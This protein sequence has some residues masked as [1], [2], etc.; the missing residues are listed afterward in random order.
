MPDILVLWSRVSIIKYISSSKMPSMMRNRQEGINELTFVS[1]QASCITA[2]RTTH[3]QLSIFMR[4]GVER[5]CQYPTLFENA[6][7]GEQKRLQ[8]F[9][10][11]AASPQ[12]CDLQ[13]FSKERTASSSGSQCST[14]PFRTQRGNVCVFCT[15]SR[16]TRTRSVSSFS[17]LL[18]N[19]RT[20]LTIFA[21][22]F[23]VFLQPLDVLP[24]GLQISLG[25]ARPIWSQRKGENEEKGRRRT[26]SLRY[27]KMQKI[28]AQVSFVFTKES[29]CAVFGMSI[30]YSSK[31]FKSKKRTL[32]I[33]TFFFQ[34]PWKHRF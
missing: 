1:E 14:K 33:F 11:F 18:S 27:Y 26:G 4:S 34:K 30:I 22:F 19:V 32:F 5:L 6:N 21:L 20:R 3:L 17:H 7:Q 15:K 9:L 24:D 8:F 25:F 13:L 10:F 31:L 23:V 28:S 29:V 2:I 12:T 16:H